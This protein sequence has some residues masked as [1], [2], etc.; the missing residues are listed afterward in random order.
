MA[1]DVFDGARG[2]EIGED[3]GLLGRI[4]NPAADIGYGIIE[5]FLGDG[6]KDGAVA[7]C[8]ARAAMARPVGPAP[9]TPMM[10]IIA[11]RCWG[12]PNRE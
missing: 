6:F 8:A 3:A 12:D 11:G 10:E 4:W 2:Y 7:G 9:M 5:K 1:A